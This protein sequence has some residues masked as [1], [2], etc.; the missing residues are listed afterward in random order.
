MTPWTV[1]G[2]KLFIFDKVGAINGKIIIKENKESTQIQI[3][4]NHDSYTFEPKSWIAGV[5]KYDLS[6]GG[7]K[8]P[9]LEITISV[10]AGVLVGQLFIICEQM[11]IFVETNESSFE[12]IHLLTINGEIKMSSDYVS[13]QNPR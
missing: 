5:Q 12:H 11:N 10:P 1:E 7:Q 6:C 8:R 3:S 13:P 4:S 9:D 2:T